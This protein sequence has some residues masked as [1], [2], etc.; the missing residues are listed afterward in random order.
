MQNKKG[1]K[2]KYE[3][4]ISH[5]GLLKIEGWARD[6]L[7]DKQIAEDKII[8][9]EATLCRWKNR[10]PQ[11]M[12]AL[13]KGKEVVDREVENSLLKRAMGYDY[14]ETTE[15][16][17]KNPDTGE[18]EMKI[19]KRINKHMAPDTT[20]LIYWLKNRKPVEWRDKKELSV[21]ETSIK[22]TI[23]EDT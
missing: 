9:N 6:G 10:F 11:I 2:G 13:K 7:V 20:A 8:I 15:E 23:S 21:E 3:Y 1:S 22:V 17:V 14:I 5:E 12:Q 18:S 19:T 16:L 4:W